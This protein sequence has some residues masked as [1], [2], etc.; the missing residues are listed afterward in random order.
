MTERSSDEIGKAYDTARTQVCTVKKKPN[1]GIERQLV[2]CRLKVKTS[3]MQG[4]L[5]TM[6]SHWSQEK[7]G[8]VVLLARYPKR[9]KEEATLVHRFKNV[10][11]FTSFCKRVI[12]MLCDLFVYLFT[13]STVVSSPDAKLIISTY[14]SGHASRSF[15]VLLVAKGLL[16]SSIT[17]H[18]LLGVAVSTI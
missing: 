17:A 18:R 7:K 13:L 16:Q 12:F 15:K 6:K 1:R 10:A 3:S 5:F 9:R 2:N 4:L 14:I 8:A 11:R